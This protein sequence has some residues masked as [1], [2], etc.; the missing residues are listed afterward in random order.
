MADVDT[1]GWPQARTPSPPR[2]ERT[3]EQ[4][5][6]QWSPQPRREKRT[7]EQISIEF[8][9]S[10]KWWCFKLN[11]LLRISIFILSTFENNIESG[12]IETAELQRTFRV[13]EKMWRHYVLRMVTH[14][15]FLD[16]Y[17]HSGDMA[18]CYRQMGI[19]L[20]YGK[21][22]MD[23]ESRI[24]EMFDQLMKENYMAPQDF[25]WSVAAIRFKDALE[26]RRA[27]G[28]RL[29]LPEYLELDT[30]HHD[31]WSSAREFGHTAHHCTLKV[32]YDEVYC[33]HWEPSMDFFEWEEYIQ[34]IGQK[35][36]VRY[37]PHSLLNVILLKAELIFMQNKEREKRERK[38]REKQEN[39]VRKW[40]ERIEKAK[41]KEQAKQEAN[42]LKQKEKEKL[43]ELKARKLQEAKE[44]K[45][46][47]E[48]E[49]DEAKMQK[50]NKEREKA[51]Q[52]RD[53]E[54]EK[55]KQK[56]DVVEKTK[57]LQI[58]G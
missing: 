41:R 24:A 44:A 17:G 22:D 6:W 40:K 49:K 57:G 30:S 7:E 33:K 21:W 16:W 55:A 26:W 27:L 1:G 42:R 28:K 14:N 47:K 4:K 12:N 31:K 23:E 48:K 2:D 36:R 3:E 56:Q 11:Q 18:R 13:M 38:E 15:V 9:R 32:G 58:D 10:S 20:Y 35:S 37:T 25:R 34:S 19:G 52:K 8:S 54:T 39:P 43:E 29:L 53:K 45:E 51:M 50:L 46:L 5:N